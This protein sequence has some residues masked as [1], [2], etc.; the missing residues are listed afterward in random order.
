MFGFCDLFGLCFYLSP[1]LWRQVCCHALQETLFTLFKQYSKEE[2]NNKTKTTSLGT[3]AFSLNASENKYIVY[4]ERAMVL[5][6]VSE[7]V[8]E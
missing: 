1:K 8:S 3:V 6:T 4:L 2:I 5:G 7:R